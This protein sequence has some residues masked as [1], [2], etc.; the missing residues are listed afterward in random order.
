MKLTKKQKLAIGSLKNLAPQE[1]SIKLGIPAISVEDYLRN[2][3]YITAQPGADKHYS[4]GSPDLTEGLFLKI[5]GFWSA[6]RNKILLIVILGFVIY[7][8][9]LPN[10]FVSDDLPL[11]R[12]PDLKNPINLLINEPV[13]ALINSLTYTLNYYANGTNPLGYHLVNILFH[14]LL[15]LVAYFFL[16]LLTKGRIAFLASLIFLVVPLHTETVIWVSGRHYILYSIFVLLS[17]IL[18][19]FAAQPKAPLR[20]RLWSVILFVF[21]VYSFPEQ[22]L[23]LPFLLILVDFYQGKLVHRAKNYWPYFLLAVIFTFLSLNRVFL[24]VQEVNGDVTQLSSPQINFV[25]ADIVAISTYLQLF[26][27]PLG[28]TF[29]HETVSTNSLEIIIRLLVLIIFFGAPLYFIKKN[30]FFL[31]S[32]GIFIVALSSTITPFRVSW[33]VAERYAYLASLGLAMLA[34]YFINLAIERLKP[35]PTVKY[36][37]TA[38]ILV[39]SVVTFMRGFDWKD[40]DSLW[41]ATV[42]ASPGSSKAWN[43]MGDYYGRHGDMQASFNAFVRATQ[44]NPTYPDAWHN[45]GNTLMQMGK[46]DESIPYFEKSLQFNPNL[47]EAYNNLALVYHKK[48]DQPKAMEMINKSLK[49]N[50]YAAKTYSAWAFIE[51]EN[52]NIDKAKE[53][54]QKGLAIDPGNQALLQ[55]L[56]MVEKSQ[57]PPQN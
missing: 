17:L 23:V 2:H 22:G 53:A 21:A 38:I 5:T 8:S 9:A 28:L 39:Y 51:Y 25:L 52:K 34:A 31:L 47:I 29:Y 18:H 54:L 46:L 55:N 19:L 50:P 11:L 1:I 40:E 3:G 6:N 7:A 14:I 20:Y 35:N 37:V 24:R 15:T 10:G 45:A 12:S 56:Q 13:S 42:K 16:S 49:I 41:L 33:I 43:N 44:I 27:I 30:R 32:T 26:L 57:T 48:G 4:E 36:L